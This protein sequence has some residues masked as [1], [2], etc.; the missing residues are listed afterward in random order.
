[1]M[2]LALGLVLAGLVMA[3]LPSTAPAD[4]TAFIGCD[5]GAGSPQPSHKCLT[6]DNLG[7]FF[8]SSSETSYTF[9]LYVV[10]ETGEKCF[11]PGESARADVLTS[12][13][14]EI[15]TPGD[16]KAIWLNALTLEE[17]EWDF[18]IEEPPPLPPPTV[19]V[20][21]LIPVTSTVDPGC[22]AAKKR[23]NKLR[24]RMKKATP[25]QRAKLRVKLKK[26][27]LAVKRAC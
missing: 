14:F 5:A 11:I 13:A 1:M 23:V 12:I 27:R 7:A 15:N 16:Y 20:P 9:C 19:I 3:A 6:T 2:R 21:P 10:G 17:P 26:A 25:A 18:T 24:V 8:K 4:T 22:L